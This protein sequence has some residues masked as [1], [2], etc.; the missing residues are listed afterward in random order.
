MT[1]AEYEALREAWVQGKMGRSDDLA[2]LVTEAGD[3]GVPFPYFRHSP[4]E[5]L[6]EYAKGPDRGD[7]DRVPKGLRRGSRATAG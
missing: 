7:E 3:Q 1:R 6:A 5:Y 2:K 4:E